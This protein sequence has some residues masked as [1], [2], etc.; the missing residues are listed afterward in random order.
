MSRSSQ[1]LSSTSV[2]RSLLAAG[3]LLSLAWSC[4]TVDADCSNGAC[5]CAAGSSCDFDC[6]APPCNV[7]CEGD[8]PECTAACGNGSCT[9]GPGSTCEFECQSPPCH[10]DCRA[11]TDCRGTCANGTC[12]CA[13]GSRCELDC[14]AGP[15]HVTCEGGHERCDGECANG[16]C[17]C[18]PD[19]RCDFLCQD[20]NCAVECE[21]GSTCVLRCPDGR[22]G[23][24]GC[25]FTRCAAG[26]PVLCEA[27][28][29]LVCGAGCDVLTELAPAPAQSLAP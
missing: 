27:E 5:V 12:T 11:E 15:C 4:R 25:Q 6:A 16:T 17:H 29:A 18:G 24:Q 1:R 21:A 23:E 22:L 28:Q 26:E 19:S 3:L 20:S 2:L 7:E 8:N 10:V 13:A 14:D 9:C